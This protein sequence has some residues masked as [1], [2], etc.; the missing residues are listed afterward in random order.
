MNLL[1]QQIKMESVL[2]PETGLIYSLSVKQGSYVTDGQL[3]AQIYEPGKVRL[4]AYVDEP[5]LGKIE[6]RQPVVIKW[7]TAQ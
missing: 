6:S 1:E 3:L 5:D 7:T 4:R 2:A